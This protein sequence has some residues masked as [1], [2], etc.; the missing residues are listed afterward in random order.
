MPMTGF[1]IVPGGALGTELITAT[2]RA[3][4]PAVVVQIGKSTVV[5][6][7]ML[8]AA[9]PVSGGV[10][11]MTFPVQGTR[12]VSGQATDYS[13]SF[14]APQVLTG[15]FNAEFN[16]KAYV[17]GIPYY[18]FEGLVQQDA[19]VVPILWAR[20]NDAGNY[21]SDLLATKL[22]AALSANSALDIFSLNDLVSASNPTQ[23]NVG[24]I[25]R[26]AQTWWRAGSTAI[27]AISST[28]TIT[29]ANVLASLASAQKLS[30]GEMPSCGICSPGF[31]T[32]LAADAIG[33]ESYLVDQEGTYAR[34]AEG[35]TIAF[36][37]LN[38]GGVPVYQDLYYPNDT[39]LMWLNFNYLNFKIHE[40]AAFQI[41]GP[42]S[43]LPQFQLGYIMALL[44]L[45]E[46]T[47]SKCVAQ[48]IYSAFTG[49]YTI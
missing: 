30:G 23:G 4:M 7:S 43:L 45:L 41:A 28:A 12:M 29:R 13:G 36:P 11:P 10:S 17:V 27:T 39:T 22:F 9:E 2:R 35:A 14:T 5:L 31:W 25:D 33:A 15:L 26:S 46:A 37:A 6:S 32:A 44:V 38:I 18:M 19:E 8:A 3:I 20:M 34:A 47:C 24:N 48:N 49:A 40:A 1:G 21:I 16:L 42:E